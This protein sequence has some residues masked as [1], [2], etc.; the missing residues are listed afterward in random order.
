[1]S[2]LQEAEG[3]VLAR[4]LLGVNRL[5]RRNI[6]NG[7]GINQTLLGTWLFLAKAMLSSHDQATGAV[8]LGHSQ[9]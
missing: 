7:A 2:N 4:L 1:M 6:S 3:E 9:V 5:P 8:A